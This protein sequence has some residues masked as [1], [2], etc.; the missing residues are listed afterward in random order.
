MD[1]EL[2][3]AAFPHFFSTVTGH[4]PFPWQTRLVERVAR[5]GWPDGL[6]LPTASGKTACIE[7]AVF[8]LALQAQ[9]PASERS[10]PRRI[11]FVVDRRI[12][13]DGAFRHASRLAS[14]LRDSDNSV[15]QKVAERLRS[16][17]G[18]LLPLGCERLRGGMRREN[19]WARS[20]SQP[21]VITCT[22][23][24]VGSRLLFRSYDG[25]R[26][27]APVHA[28]LAGND[29]LVL[30][31]EA[32]CA[33]PFMQTAGAV[34][35]L[36]SP[37]WAEE[38]IGAPFKLV[39]LSATLPPG[40]ESVLELDEED[41]SHPVL[42]PRVY[43]GK[44]AELHVAKK[45]KLKRNPSPGDRRTAIDALANELVTHALR[46]RDEGRMR[47][48]VMA[49][50]VATV[51]AVARKLRG[52]FERGE[53]DVVLMTGRMR[54]VDRDELGRRWTPLLQASDPEDI[55]R[56]VLVVATQCL[57]VGA[58]FDFDGLVTECAS[59][60]ALRQRFGRLDR[61]GTHRDTQAVIV[62]RKDQ[63][64]T[65][66]DDP[67]YGASLAN[68]WQWLMEQS[69][70]GWIEM[71]TAAVDSALPDAERERHDLLSDLVAP[72]VDA[73]VMLPAHVDRWV[74][75]DP[76]PIPDPEPAIFLHGPRRKN[77]SE[78]HVLWRADLMLT[79]AEPRTPEARHDAWISA[80]SLCPPTGLE[81]LTT[82]L[83][84]LR[85]WMR[86]ESLG[87]EQQLSDIEGVGYSDEEPI[88]RK[89]SMHPVLLWRGRDEAVVVTDPEKVRPG[90]FVVIP[91][92]L[93]GHES[94]GHLPTEPDSPPPLDVADQAH[95]LARDLPILRLVPGVTA[96]WPE[97]PIITRLKAWA[98][99]PGRLDDP[100]DLPEILAR[101]AADESLP[102]WMRTAAKALRSPSDRK[103]MG[104]PL[105]GYVLIGR[106]RLG[107]YRSEEH[108]FA[109]V[110]DT[111][112]RAALPVWLE[113]HLDGV[114]DTVS[115]L[116]GR[117]GL[118][119][120]LTEDLVL[121]ARLHDVGKADERFQLLLHGG[122]QIRLARTSAVLAKSDAMPEGRA[123]YVRVR[124]RCGVPVGFRHELVSLRLAE[125]SPDLLR[126]AHD[127]ELVLHLIASHH[128]RC[129]PFAPVIEEHEP[130][131]VAF[132]LG[133]RVLRCPSETR[134]ERLDS[135]VAE[136][137]WLL[138]R[139][140]GWWG[141]AY[142]E[143]ILRLADHRRS[144]EEERLAQA[145][146]EGDQD[147]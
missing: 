94:F 120:G 63:A 33:R 48:A 56:P 134:L 85:Q 128:G 22:V 87:D 18:E 99:E 49:N 135:G 125:S 129:R 29:A 107:V 44:P 86:G 61:F 110:E 43:A 68:T 28:G 34:Q 90:D 31:D 127:P 81:A 138:V 93:D 53:A 73:P 105:G 46:F 21:V 115:R 64:K 95:Q 54:P 144:E 9:Q 131:K 15:V 140:Y 60:D 10:A 78:V 27:L 16:V 75:T 130:V 8:T 142:L 66:D 100:G 82:P 38:P 74:Q 146:A 101:V 36:R 84:V 147:G 6:A 52:K 103:L 42:R 47:I 51:E 7:V 109:D 143:A 108:P 14:T 57:E 111:Y 45:A 41:R 5:D 58:D 24:Q 77:A 124:D 25:S 23:D 123:P 1:S 55:E 132:R 97:A 35:Q 69:K 26:Y 136:R 3:I 72:R 79:S 92:A 62:V 112:S 116:A 141:L 121:A 80:V 122:S 70:D 126:E 4:P 59:L 114:A 117:C 139:R 83:Y 40:V 37:T 137:F 32:H 88:G 106:R 12:V 2:S 65:S 17:G 30:L 96:T 104:H 39:V 113:E 91:A 102:D 13:V 118:P 67:V 20:P 98:D 11:F 89:R 50:R 119:A 19:A 133:G 145:A 71:G 76:N